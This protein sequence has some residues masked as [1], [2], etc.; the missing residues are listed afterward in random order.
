MKKKLLLSLLLC[1]GLLLTGCS[2][3]MVIATV[4][5]TGVY[6]RSVR[7]VITAFFL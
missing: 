4:N 5:G 6:E 1:T 3:G 2:K 7:D